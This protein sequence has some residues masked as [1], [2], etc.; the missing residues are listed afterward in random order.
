[1]KA[2]TA[3]PVAVGFGISSGQQAAAAAAAGADGVIVGSRAIEAAEA[4]GAA[5]LREFV[6][7]L[8]AA[9]C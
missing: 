4:G 2:A 8:A 6:A 1:V 5:G 9:M 3:V 7:S